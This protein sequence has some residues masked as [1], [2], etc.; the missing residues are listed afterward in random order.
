[1]D[2]KLKGSVEQK[3][4]LTWSYRTFAYLI[5][6]KYITTKGRWIS[7]ASRHDTLEKSHQLCTIQPEM[8]NLNLT[9]RKHQKNPTWKILL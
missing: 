6:N 1:M 4:A 7:H 5:K 3:Q 9:I 8:N 2:A